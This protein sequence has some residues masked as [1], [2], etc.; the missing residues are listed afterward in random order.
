MLKLCFLNFSIIFVSSLIEI[1][2]GTGVLCERIKELN[3]LVNVSGFDIDHDF[4]DYANRYNSKC[5]FIQADARTIKEDISYDYVLSHT[6]M[7]YMDETTF[8]DCNRR[9]I[10]PTG[11]LI[12]MSITP[13]TVHHPISIND[14]CSFKLKIGINALIVSSRKRQ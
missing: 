14:E 11:E 12:I 9:L 3:P 13:Q 6:I 1:G 5:R 2:C 8:F 4:I 7:E 10:S